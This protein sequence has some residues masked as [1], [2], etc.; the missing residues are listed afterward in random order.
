M[1]HWTVVEPCFSFGKDETAGN[2]RPAIGAAN[3]VLP[4]AK[5][6]L[7]LQLGDSF[8]HFCPKGLQVFQV[9]Q[10]E[11]VPAEAKLQVLKFP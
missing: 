5:L 10:G 3:Q 4:G 7:L 2:P 8:L 9:Q 6:S 1:I 11:L